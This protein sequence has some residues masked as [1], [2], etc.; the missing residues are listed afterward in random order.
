MEEYLSNIHAHVQATSQ[1][2]KFRIY[3]NVARQLGYSISDEM[4]KVRGRK[5]VETS[6]TL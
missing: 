3:L 2:N 4:T 5:Q 1:L 6:C